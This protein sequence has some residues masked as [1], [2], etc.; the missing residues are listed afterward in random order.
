MKNL[1]L[2]LL[3]LLVITACGKG[4]ET[5]TVNPDNSELF[6]GP[7]T[8]VIKA[9]ASDDDFVHIKLGEAAQIRSLDPLFAESNS[10]WRMINLIYDRLV[11]LDE[12]GAPAPGL[13]KRWTVNEDSTQYIFHLKTTVNFHNSPIFDGNTGRRFVASDVKYIFDRMGFNDVPD[14]TA[15]N[16]NDITGFSIYHSEQTLVKDPDLRVYPSV[17]GVRTQD[18]ST[19]VFFLNKPSGDLL[20]RLAHPMASV[21]PK[22]SV[23]S[24]DGLIQNAAGTGAFRLLSREGNAHLLTINKDY[25]GPKPNI[26]RL[27]II[28]GL[29]ERDLFQEFAQTN[30]H[31]LIEVG[32]STLL[33]IADTTGNLQD[34]YYRNYNL[35]QT[36]ITSEYPLYFN[37]NS[38]QTDQLN[39]IIPSLDERSLLINPALGTISLDSVDV[40]GTENIERPQFAVTQTKHPFYLFLLNNLAPQVNEMKYSFSMSA[41]YVMS[42][43]TTFSTLPYPGTELF[44]HWETPLYILTQQDI[45]GIS[46]THQ[47]W[48][49]DLSELTIK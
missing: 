26:N 3:P 21:Y 36:D 12:N 48:N 5:V 25:N 13:A 24:E 14:F 27:D 46:I 41:S 31:G 40:T 49:L 29:T 10:E 32:P 15:R 22:E 7:D 43:E 45:S 39:E 47:P 9:D 11:R 19:V 6:G 20:Q 35:E 34:S 8:T 38:G 1:F 23:E 37:R 2:F 4:P 44:L 17:E 18:D 33:T 16:F 30:L 42:D 28:S